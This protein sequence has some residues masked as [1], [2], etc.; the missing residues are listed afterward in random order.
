M[1]SVCGVGDCWSSSVSAV[2]ALVQQKVKQAFLGTPFVGIQFW[3]FYKSV[4]QFHLE[5][6]Y[7]VRLCNDRL[8]GYGDRALINQLQLALKNGQFG[9]AEEPGA[10]LFHP[11]ATRSFKQIQFG[12]ANLQLSFYDA[13][14]R[15]IDGVECVKF[16]AD[17]DYYKDVAGHVMFEAEATTK[18]LIDP[19]N[20]YVLRWMAGRRAGMPEF[21]P[22]Y[23]IE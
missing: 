15:T 12:E 14:V 1:A 4:K 18:R 7:Q 5:T 22:P 11:G 6:V 9:V 3:F 20:V 13:Y 16:E 19:M 8:L 17:M 2:H 10:A 21:N 23:S